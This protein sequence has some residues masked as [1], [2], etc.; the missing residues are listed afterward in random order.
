MYPRDKMNM[1]FLGNRLWY[2]YNIHG[3]AFP[4]YGCVSLEV[5]LMSPLVEINKEKAANY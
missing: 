2:I 5:S 3:R 4:I 1:S